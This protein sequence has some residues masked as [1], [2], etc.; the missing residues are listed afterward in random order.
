MSEEGETCLRELLADADVAGIV[1]GTLPDASPAAATAALEFTV[2][3]LNCV[4]EQM[5]PGDAG[6]PDPPQ[7][8][9]SLLW[10]YPT[11][12]WVVN[13]P[14]VADGAVYFGSDDNHVYAL[15][16]ETGELLWR[17]ETDDVIR[18]SPTVAGGAVYVGSNGQRSRPVKWCKSEIPA[19]GLP[20]WLHAENHKW[21]G[22]PWVSYMWLNLIRTKGRY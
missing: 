19:Y 5:L 10:R 21:L 8:D 20:A 3:L 9:E 18:S 13:A 2:G 15:D 11:G 7:A 14:T 1:A 4:P 12:E 17:F 16:T 22:L 6:P